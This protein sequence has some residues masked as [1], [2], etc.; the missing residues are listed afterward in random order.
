MQQWCSFPQQH[1]PFLANQHFLQVI[2]K[3][4]F[5]NTVSQIWLSLMPNEAYT[6]HFYLTLKAPCHWAS[7]WLPRIR[8]PL[9]WSV[10][11]SRC[12]R[13]IFH[14]SA[15]TFHN[16]ATALQENTEGYDWLVAFPLWEAVWSTGDQNQTH[17]LEIKEY[18]GSFSTPPPF[19]LL[20]RW[21]EG[22]ED[23][24]WVRCREHWY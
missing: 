11:Y 18:F 5:I 2:T 19:F 14:C 1:C 15:D 17:K 21:W 7:I 10:L 23:V 22:L 9:Q 13:G 12:S 6:K 16:S 20:L 24:Q 3:N 8:S 4:E